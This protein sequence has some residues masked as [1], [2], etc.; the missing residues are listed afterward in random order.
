MLNVMDSYNHF[1]AKQIIEA[2]LKQGIKQEV[3]ALEAKIHQ[4]TVSRIA[5]GKIKQVRWGT[6]LRLSHILNIA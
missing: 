6:M 5:S 2:L 3:I 1:G 4:S